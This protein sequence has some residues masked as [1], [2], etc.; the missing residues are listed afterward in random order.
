[1]KLR[2]LKESIIDSENNVFYIDFQG[3]CEIEAQSAEEAEEKFWEL[4]NYDKPLP[5]NL[6]EISNIEAK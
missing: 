4:I 3:S 1:M 5:H 6:Y 2:R